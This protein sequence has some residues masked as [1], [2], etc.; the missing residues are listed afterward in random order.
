M[1]Y[2]CKLHLY[3]RFMD[4][5]G[6]IEPVY[7]LKDRILPQ[8]SQETGAINLL[9]HHGLKNAYTRY[10]QKRVKET[11]SHYLP[12][13]PGVVNMTVDNDGLRYY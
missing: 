12:D 4:E 1:Y 13:L 6:N 10:C 9:T 2:I 7:L 3:Y 11:L 8:P 5:I